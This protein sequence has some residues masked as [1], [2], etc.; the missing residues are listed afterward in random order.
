VHRSLTGQI[1]VLE[2][3]TL[4]QLKAIQKSFSGVAVL[5]G[6]DFSLES[7]E[8]HALAGG[9]GAG[10]STLM[11][12]LMGVYTCDEGEI[13]IDG[14]RRQFSNS[15]EAR[16]S[17]I[18]MVFQEFSLIPHLTVAQNIFLTNEFGGKFGSISDKEAEKQAYAIFESM[19]V[20]IDPRTEVAKL[21]T[22]YQQLTEI[23]KALAQNAKIL[24]LDEPTS[25]LAADETEALFALINRLK[26]RGL[27]IIYISHR[28]DEIFTIA[29]RITVIRN[30]SKVI[31]SPISALSA[32]DVI[33]AI[34]GHKMEANLEWKKR[35]TR[36][37]P[38][39]LLS[40]QKLSDGRKIK[41][42]SFE[43]REG[44]ILGFAGLMGS[45]RTE[46]LNLIYGID[47]IQSGEI[48]I[49]GNQVSLKSVQ[50]AVGLGI[51]LVPEDRRK[52]G[53][54]LRHSA[55]DNLTL[56]S[57]DK[58]RSSK[59]LQRRKIEKFIVSMVEKFSIKAHSMKRDV[60]MLS[61]GNQ[62]KV[63][64]AKWFGTSPK[65]MMMD[66]PTA[67][68]DIETKIEILDIIRNFADEGKGVIFI[69]SELP[70]LLAVCDRILVLRNGNISEELLRENIP[71][72]KY[73]QM[74]TQ[75]GTYE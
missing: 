1:G 48:R 58:L 5:K 37:N 18:G 62:Q 61:G 24:I 65:I 4:V 72:E 31:D 21:S 11:K 25:S 59:I 14:E 75:G 67:G 6:V 60:V 66:E 10:K 29:Q 35:E 27:G 22:A 33:E 36:K 57:L 7:G 55:A 70:E 47:A 53:L 68:V 12:I 45:G 26:E 38:K 17:G 50:Q 3:S 54:V 40:A 39:V 15:L 73:L 74:A 13:L 49:E 20:E 32:V 23:A 42:L 30:G 44:E 8:V 71:N 41:D 16:R 2:M 51:A 63:V 69:S 43:L 64:I 28:M 34:V 9:N 52:F 46:V 56:P 19:G